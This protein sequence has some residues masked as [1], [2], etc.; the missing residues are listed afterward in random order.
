MAP[1]ITVFVQLLIDVLDK[2]VA[3]VYGASLRKYTMYFMALMLLAGLYFLLMQS[4]MLEFATVKKTGLRIKTIQ[5]GAT[6][7]LR[8]LLKNSVT[9]INF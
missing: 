9:I 8:S 6:E 4:A 7:T 3:F 1:G 5:S 2:Y